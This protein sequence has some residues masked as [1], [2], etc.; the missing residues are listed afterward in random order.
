M[1]TDSMPGPVGDWRIP[2]SLCRGFRRFVVVVIPCV[3]AGSVLAACSAATSSAARPAA[4]LPG[5]LAGAQARWLIAAMAHL[6]IGAAEVRAHFDP[7][8]LAQQSP[9]QI[10]QVLQGIGEVTV[11]SADV[12]QSSTPCREFTGPAGQCF[13]ATVSTAGRPLQLTLTVGSD[14]LISGL[15]F[16]PVIP[17]APT[18]WQGVDAA[19]GSSLPRSACSSPTSAAAHASRCTASTPPPLRRW[20]GLQALCARR[21]RPCRGRG[22]GPLE[23]VAHR[24]RATQEPALRGTPGRAGR[25]PD[26]RAGHGRQD[27]LH[28]RQHGRQHADQPRGAARGRGGAHHHRDGEPSPGPA[29]PD[30]P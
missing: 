29:V 22:Q 13:A 10:N 6:P 28:Q 18:T 14:G 24:H 26:L 16:S 27:D 20:L 1:T 12:S 11:A 2:G 5:T 4:R 15:L 3:L 17:P 9:A 25:H 8:F 30:D 21:A 23:P 19:I 7:N